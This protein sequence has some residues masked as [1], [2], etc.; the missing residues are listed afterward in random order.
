MSGK[1]Y[2][3]NR[4]LALNALGVQEQFR[5]KGTIRASAPGSPRH[6]VNDGGT[7]RSAKEQ[8]GWRIRCDQVGTCGLSRSGWCLAGVQSLRRGCAEGCQKEELRPAEALTRK[9]SPRPDEA[10][11]AARAW[12]RSDVRLLPGLR[13]KP[14]PEA[15]GTGAVD[16]CRPRLHQPLPQALP[17]G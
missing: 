5:N 12:V 4:E 17:L 13:S 14:W 16:G 3:T 10:P 1:T 8:T 9:V 2:A 6:V 7:I 11:G 15:Q